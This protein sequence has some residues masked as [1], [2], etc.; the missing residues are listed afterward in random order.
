MAKHGHAVDH[1]L[2]PPRGR[3]SR[4][5]AREHGAD[6]ATQ[7]RARRRSFVATNRKRAKLQ[8]VEVIELNGEWCH[9]KR[10]GDVIATFPDV[11][12]AVAAL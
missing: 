5:K 6:R 1:I 7:D 12:S 3:V 4:A 8:D 10:G 11:S 2:S 9:R